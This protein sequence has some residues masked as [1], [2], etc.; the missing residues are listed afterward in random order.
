MFF[1]FFL[2]LKPVNYLS[3][4][5]V[6]S[7]SF[8]FLYAFSLDFKELQT[9][10]WRSPKQS[11]R[12]HSNPVE[13]KMIT[14]PDTGKSFRLKFLASRSLMLSNSD[15][16][17]QHNFLHITVVDNALCATE[18]SNVVSTPTPH[19]TSIMLCLPSLRTRHPP[20]EASFF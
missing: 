15:S 4:R 6:Y 13:M 5:L 16:T 19:A 10:K 8:I 7:N 3:I 17:H 14:M 11:L 12:G 2:C 20:S 18:V 9:G 1:L